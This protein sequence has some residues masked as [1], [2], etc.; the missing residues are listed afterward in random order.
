LQR[1]AGRQPADGTNR[2]TVTR[3]ITEACTRDHYGVNV[4]PDAVTQQLLVG[5]RYDD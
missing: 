2:Y 4:E 3:A 5:V 1:D